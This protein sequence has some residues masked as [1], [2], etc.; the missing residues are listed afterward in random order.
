MKRIIFYTES[1]WAF[2]SIH[3]ELSKYLFSHGVNAEVLPWNRQ[4]RKAEMTEL[5]GMV[6]T[7]VTSPQGYTKLADHYKINPKRIIMIVHARLDLV[8]LIKQKGLG[9]F[10][11]PKQLV[12]ISKH[13]QLLA[14]ELGVKRIPKL[15][16][17]GVNTDLYMTAPS[18]SLQTVGYAGAFHIREEF[19]DD[20]IDSDY[21]AQ[22]SLKRAYLVQEAA[23]KAGLKLRVA[24]LYHN[25]FVTMPG[26]YRKVDCVV[27]SSS[28][29]GA[30]LPALEAAAAGR[31][32]IST[33]VGHWPERALKGGGLSVPIDEK[34]FVAETAKLLLFYKDHPKEFAEKCRAIQKYAKGY[35]WNEV[36]SDW[37]KLLAA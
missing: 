20:L 35:D 29:E 12:V 37:I 18:T 5:A 4:Y 11:K 14:K 9:E 8:D 30:G 2:G 21:Q 22:N 24:Q 17:L 23:Q 26:F 32:V 3:Y 19:D 16:Y 31:L 15:L 25:S 36:I 28:Q 1:E 34:Q 6:D 10:T 13:L 33:P 7:F 27:V